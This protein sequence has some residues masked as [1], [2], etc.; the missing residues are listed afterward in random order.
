MLPQNSRNAGVKGVGRLSYM[1]VFDY[2]TLE[3]LVLGSLPT[4]CSGNDAMCSF[5]T[6]SLKEFL[7]AH[8]ASRPVIQ[9]ITARPNLD[10]I[11]SRD[12][13]VFIKQRSHNGA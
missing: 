8:R 9:I 10:F 12:I 5:V 2:S 6:Q 4:G 13:L 11:Y 3:L 1:N 7:E